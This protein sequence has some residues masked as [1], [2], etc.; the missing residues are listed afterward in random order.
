MLDA[1]HRMEHNHVVEQCYDSMH[2]QYHFYC[3]FLVISVA[4]I[5]YH[6]QYS[7]KYII[8]G[9]ILWAYLLSDL[10]FDAI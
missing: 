5:I 10:P 4:H 3:G 7:S 9:D 2:L 6:N 8:Y 1:K